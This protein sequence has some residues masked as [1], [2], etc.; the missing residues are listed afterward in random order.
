MTAHFLGSYSLLWVNSGGS[1]LPARRQVHLYKR[2]LVPRAERATLMR[3]PAQRF[4][5]R[6][7]LWPSEL[8]PGAALSTAGVVPFPSLAAEVSRWR[9]PTPSVTDPT[10]RGVTRTASSPGQC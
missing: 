3:K 10:T 5:N 7:S 9:R 1:G 6:A 8:Q 2:T 4:D